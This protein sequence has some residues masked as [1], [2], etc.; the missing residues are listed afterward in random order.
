MS[1]ESGA[2]WYLTRSCA[3][4]KG[5]TTTLGVS[6]EKVGLTEH[7]GNGQAAAVSRM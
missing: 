3:A 5:T 1:E 7:A 2:A 6:L 4:D